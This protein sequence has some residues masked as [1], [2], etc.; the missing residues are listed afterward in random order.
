VSAAVG[1]FALKPDESSLVTAIHTAVPT[2]EATAAAL[3]ACFHGVQRK[4]KGLR[5]FAQSLLTAGLGFFTSIF[6]F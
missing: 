1:A 3:R 6:F 2:V 5:A 4:S